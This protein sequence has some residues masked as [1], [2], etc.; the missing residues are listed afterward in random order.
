[1]EPTDFWDGNHLSPVR[2]M[3]WTRLGTIHRQGQMRP[4]VMV[5]G[6]IACEDTREMPLMEDDHMVQTFPADTPNQALDI[7]VLPRT[8]GRNHD[9]FDLHVLDALLK[10]RAVDA[11]AVAEQIPWCLL[12]RE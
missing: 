1:M 8:P 10:G 6:K 9:L 5:I 2:T 7:W 3:D 11:V 4:P 12:P